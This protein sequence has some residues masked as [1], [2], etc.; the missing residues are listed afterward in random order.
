[1]KRTISTFIA[2][3]TLIT[4]LAQAERLIGQ[5]VCE[6][7]DVKTYIRGT[8]QEGIPYSLSTRYVWGEIMNGAQGMLRVEAKPQAGWGLGYSLQA[9]LTVANGAGEFNSE[10]GQNFWLQNAVTQV[11]L[12][13]HAAAHLDKL[14]SG[15]RNSEGDWLAFDSH[16]I[17]MASGQGHYQRFLNLTRAESLPD[18]T[19]QLVLEGNDWR[20]DARLRCP[21]VSQS[22]VLVH[23]RIRYR[24]GRR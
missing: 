13:S 18:W 23:E 11:S 20:V 8:P 14:A 19:G 16:T 2:L 6:Y 12:P 4:P 9:T 3:S 17:Q 1:M 10:G 21:E 7:S 22:P 15:A 24:Q 5:M